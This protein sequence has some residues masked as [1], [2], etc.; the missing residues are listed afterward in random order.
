VVDRRGSIVD[1]DS[2]RGTFVA[3]WIAGCGGDDGTAGS[4]EG[5]GGEASSAGE[6]STGSDTGATSDDDSE[7][8]GMGR[9]EGPME[10]SASSQET[11]DP[12]DCS[13]GAYAPVCGV[14]GMTYDAACGLPCVPVEIACEG[15]CPCSGLLC[16]ELECSAGEQVCHTTIGGP[17]GS[18]P[19]YQCGTVPEECLPDPDCSC[20]PE[21]GCTCVEEPEDFFAIECHAP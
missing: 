20:F 4:S 19:S 1:M 17:A 10:A 3:I 9:S 12:C 21:I 6:V 14:D 13:M 15:E 16:G 2:V 8:T 7:S 18:R 5:S 11:G